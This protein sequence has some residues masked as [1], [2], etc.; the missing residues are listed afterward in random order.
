M[1][2]LN[3]VPKC[4]PTLLTYTRNTPVPNKVA[5]ELHKYMIKLPHSQ[6]VG[7]KYSALN[8]LLRHE[9]NNPQLIIIS[10]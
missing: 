5:S 6:N 1:V 9:T 3:N 2:I 8:N 10:M 4:L 7:S